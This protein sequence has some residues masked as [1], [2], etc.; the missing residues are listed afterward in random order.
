[1]IGKEGFQAICQCNNQT[2]L[3]LLLPS[4]QS[5]ISFCHLS[6]KSRIPLTDHQA[7]GISRQYYRMVQFPAEGVRVNEEVSVVTREGEKNRE[8]TVTRLDDG[9]LA[10]SLL[11]S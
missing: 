5:C 4:D 6:S 10:R 1:M 11:H 3:Y 2:I 8:Q 9:L 7:G